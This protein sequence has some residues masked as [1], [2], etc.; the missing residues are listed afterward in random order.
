A[1]EYYNGG[2]SRKSYARKILETY[3]EFKKELGI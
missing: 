1:L 2:N 3:E